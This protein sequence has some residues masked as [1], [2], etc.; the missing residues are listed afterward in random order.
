MSAPGPVRVML[1]A[2][3]ASGDS[4]GAGLA[5]ELKARLGERLR[6][7]GVGG[8]RMAGEGVVSPFPIAELSIF[9]VLEALQAYRRVQRRIEDTVRLAQAETPHVAVLIDAWGFNVRLARRLRQALPD[10]TLVKYVAPQV[11]AS[12]PARAREA[13]RVFDHLLTL[14]AFEA[15]H[16]EQTGL[17]VTFVGSP[18]LARSFAHADP[19]GFRRSIGAGA[20]ELI[21]LVA[22]GSRPSEIARVLPPFQEAVTRLK[23]DRPDL[24]VV[25]PVA[26]TVAKAVKARVAEWPFPAVV[27]E[28]DALKDGAMAAADVA[29][30]C[31]GTVTT[32]LAVAGAPMV[33]GYRTGAVTYQVLKRLIR[34]R[35]ITLFNIAADE[36]V[37]PE[38]IQ[39]ECNGEALARELAR[40]LDD[41]ALR[42]D[43][44]ERQFA[45]L[46]KLGRG[47]PDPAVAAAEA[48]LAVLEAR[49]RL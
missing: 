29:L 20:G 27:A 9:G 35:F 43:Q 40:R 22:P 4:L 26:A 18:A 46:E 37:A 42:R 15:R 31:S 48:V 47:G 21:L 12:R 11:W 19:E 28:E 49:G 7:S 8:E 17:P 3:E 39:H 1:V 23:R 5:R 38:L 14:F 25:V 41:P 10:T 34:T 30:A 36:A 33:V 45:A 44:R 16:F 13:A 32:E 6:L 2:A 24:H